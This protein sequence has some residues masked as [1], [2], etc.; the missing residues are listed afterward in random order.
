M[1]A[2]SRTVLAEVQA[3]R[4][5][6]LSANTESDPRFDASK[7]LALGTVKAFLAGGTKITRGGKTIPSEARRIEDL[8]RTK[9]I[10]AEGVDSRTALA[11]EFAIADAQLSASTRAARFGG[12]VDLDVGMAP[13][14]L[15]RAAP[16]DHHPD[17]EEQRPGREA[18]VDHVERRAGLGLASS[19][20]RCIQPG[21]H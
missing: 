14:D 17:D 19:D 9:V 6:V 10:W 3:R 7:S 4:Q 2:I 8:S 12:Y 15:A 11:L 16:G 20:A 1:A 5:A 13:I 18:V 21:G